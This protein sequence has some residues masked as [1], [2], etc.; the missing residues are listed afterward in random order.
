[1]RKLL[2]M[3]C[4]FVMSINAIHA[5]TWIQ[6][7]Q[8]TKY[9]YDDGSYA[10]GEVSID[11]KDYYF[12][13]D[14]KL[15]TSY[16]YTRN[17]NTYFYRSN[18]EK[19]KNTWL[20]ILGNQYHF[21]DIGMMDKGSRYLD[22]HAY[23]FNEDGSMVSNQW[24]T[25]NQRLY[26]YQEDGTRYHK[27]GWQK[28]QGYTYYVND[29]DS[30]KVG[31]STIDGKDYYF[32]QDG[33]LKTSY[34]YTRNNN[35][36][37]YRSNGEKAK[38]IW[39]TIL[40][41]Q[42]HFNDIGMMDKGLRYIDYKAY[43][44]DEKGMMVY[45]QWL[46]MN[47]KLY[48]FQKD[49]T[50]YEHLGWQ[51]M[52]GQTY[53][54]NEDYSFKVGWQEI[55]GSEYYFDEKGVLLHGS[56]Y[57]EN[58]KIY[59]LKHTGKK[60]KDEVIYI[61]GKN[62]YFDQNGVMSFGLTLKDG[63]YYYVNEDASFAKSCWKIIG[64]KQFYFNYLGQ[65]YEQVGWSIIGN[66]R[67]YFNDDYSTSTGMCMIDQDI[68]YFSMNGV[69]YQN[70]FLSYGNETYYFDEEGKMVKD[71]YIT[72]NQK[73]YYFDAEG[74]RGLGLVEING[75]IFFMNE[76]TSVIQNDFAS[77]N[78]KTYYFSEDGSMLQGSGF[79]YINDE[80]YYFSEDYSI[81]KDGEYQ[82]DGIYYLFDE[83]GKVYRN[84]FVEKDGKTY[85]YG[86][87]GSKARS[88]WCTINKQK[89]YFFYD[90]S[91]AKG[92][93]NMDHVYYIFSDQGVYSHI[94][95]ASWV[96]ENGRNVIYSSLGH[97]IDEAKGLIVDLSEHNGS[98]DWEVLKDNVYGVILRAGYV[99]SREDYDFD[100]YVSKCEEYDI[101]Y[102][103]Y[104]Y[105]YALDLEDVQREINLTLQSL[106]DC[107]P[108][109]PVY[110]DMEDADGWKRKQ[111][112]PSNEM[113]V[114]ICKEFCDAMIE[115]GYETGI[116][117]SLSWFNGYLNSELLDPYAKWVAQWNSN[118]G[119][120]KACTY[121]KAY[122]MWQYTS[123]GYVNGI[124][125]RVDAN[126]W[127]GN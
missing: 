6:Q 26:Y 50:R 125:G 92:K 54:V 98:I 38:N 8:N 40:G 55:D 68:Y 108:T 61:L 66:N 75:E 65:R 42:Y 60:A 64:G 43:Y 3:I 71:C 18:G 48:Y 39:L 93:V 52:N 21:N 102:G 94:E 44:F 14:G 79:A 124:S 126:I 7:E 99:Y 77:E 107:N 97:R 4:L 95:N 51:Q 85:Y 69:M 101:P 106:K 111:G 58:G 100:Y 19:A 41:N 49:G 2:I 23:Y 24:L 20:T 91:M 112:F 63:K 56:L 74:R 115:H 73:P 13:Q 76:D 47:Q 5:D 57:K 123:N 84:R 104:V 116:Y 35:T 15:K 16:F 121:E 86:S 34:F 62:Y 81:L 67:Y 83:N 27:K 29:D 127:Y 88:K 46:K 72:I 36:Y 105:S 118:D 103:I 113:L 96:K 70:R 33:K 22:G 9:Q 110:I 45:D 30:F 78:G 25:L 80:R 90:G 117:A 119:R 10:I 87:D 37:F 28:I 114:N 120:A 82:I 122:Q 17:N 109:L 12:D 59:Y 53:Y 31:E 32:D 1:M 11:G 89:Y